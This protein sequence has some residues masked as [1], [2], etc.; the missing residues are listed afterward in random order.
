MSMQ[1]FENNGRRRFALPI[2]LLL[3]LF[4]IAIIG[5]HVWRHHG[6]DLGTGSP[7]L[8]RILANAQESL[9]APDAA[10]F[11]AIM[12]RDAPRYLESARKLAEARNALE[13]QIVADPYDTVATQRS[14]AVWQ[15]SA[16]QF[17]SDISDPLIEALGH[18]SPEGR[19][20][21]VASRHRSQQGLRTP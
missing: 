13:R 9:A 21:L 2:S 14:F 5:G 8:P 6:Y 20:K 3:N 4:L 11:G 15:A 12:R 1:S 7:S 16:T 18:V 17:L 19:Q 10:A